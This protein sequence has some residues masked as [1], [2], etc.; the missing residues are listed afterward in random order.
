LRIKNG[1]LSSAALRRLGIAQ[2]VYPF[3]EIVFALRKPISL[4]HAYDRTES[5]SFSLGLKNEKA[6]KGGYVAASFGLVKD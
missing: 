3:A 2:G 6:V 4:S 5:R 1:V